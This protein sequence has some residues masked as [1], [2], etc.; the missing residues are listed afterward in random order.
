MPERDTFSP[1]EFDAF[2]EIMNMGFGQ[3]AVLLSEV[4][5]V[6]TALSVPQIRA[7][8]PGLVRA[9][10]EA[11]L[12]PSPSYSMVE[13][14]FFGKFA[15]R[16]FLLMPE[17]QCR[18]LGAVFADAAMPS[19]EELELGSLE[20]D[21]VMEIG[22]IIIGACVGRVA[23]L[24]GD[25]VGFQPPRYLPSP[26]DLGAI[27]AGPGESGDLALLFRT[28]FHFKDEDI[29]G[30]L[31]LVTSHESIAWLKEAVRRYIASLAP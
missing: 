27:G 14:F 5:R 15:G 12:G 4:M 20:R 11:Q 26:L 13:Q 3:A 9:Y 24:L 30:Q 28:V 22:N 21:M 29:E 10:V 2:K 31:F 19:D 18:R 1:L 25:Q 7:M 16:S 17:D 23:E 6:R 8:E